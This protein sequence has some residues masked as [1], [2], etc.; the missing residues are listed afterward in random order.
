[1]IFKARTAGNSQGSGADT[2]VWIDQVR[3]AQTFGTLAGG[4]F[5]GFDDLTKAVAVMWGEKRTFDDELW[6]EYKKGE[7]KLVTSIR[8]DR[9]N[10]QQILAMVAGPA[11]LL[12]ESGDTIERL[13]G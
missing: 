9:E 11:F 8:L 5:L 6:P 3:Q 7:I 13:A 4:A 1:M 12:S 10:G 2:W